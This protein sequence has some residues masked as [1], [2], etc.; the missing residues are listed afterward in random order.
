MGHIPLT[1]V[2][3]EVNCLIVK[4]I[5]LPILRVNSSVILTKVQ[6]KGAYLN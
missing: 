1:S 5:L 4:D 2:I 6:N 3:R